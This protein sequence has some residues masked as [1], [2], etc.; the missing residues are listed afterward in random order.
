MLSKCT[1]FQTFER[2][3][4]LQ[5]H[6]IGGS[7]VTG[8]VV[9][10]SSTY[11]GGRAKEESVIQTVDSPSDSVR[12]RSDQREAEWI[13]ILRPTDRSGSRFQRTRNGRFMFSRA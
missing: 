13:V 6:L 7:M 2:V 10:S 5:L 11:H 3:R 4:A 8:G 9:S 12:M 1:R